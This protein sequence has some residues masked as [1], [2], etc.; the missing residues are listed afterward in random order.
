[1]HVVRL[2][3][4]KGRLATRSC[5]WVRYRLNEEVER[6]R[7]RGGCNK[8]RWILTGLKRTR[9]TRAL[10]PRGCCKCTP[11]QLPP[12]ARLGSFSAVAVAAC[13]V[14]FSGTRTSRTWVRSGSGLGAMP[15][16]QRRPGA[17]SLLRCRWVLSI[18][19]IEFCSRQG[20]VAIQEPWDAGSANFQSSTGREKRPHS[21]HCR[22]KMPFGFLR[23]CGWFR[24]SHV[25]TRRGRKHIVSDSA[26]TAQRTS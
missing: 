22:S 20:E 17:S 18:P 5:M 13:P 3:S 12:S 25:R 7:D 6:K 23:Q 9:A 14:Y 24:E 21:F 8:T 19:R 11:Y 26:G 15:I 2:I 4:S 1:M 16:I 10:W